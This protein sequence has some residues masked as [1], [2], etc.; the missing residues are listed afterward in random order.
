MINV[1]YVGMLILVR[2]NKEEPSFEASLFKKEKIENTVFPMINNPRGAWV[3][4]S[5]KRP[6]L[7]FC[8]G[9]DLTVREFEPHIGLCADS[10]EPAWDSLSPSLSAPPLLVRALKNK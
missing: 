6:T 7:D 9:Q 1:H 2:S 8:S 4:Q 3:A 5:A 10:A